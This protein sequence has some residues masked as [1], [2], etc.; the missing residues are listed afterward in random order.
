MSVRHE[1]RKSPNDN[2]PDEITLRKIGAYAVY[3]SDDERSGSIKGY[4]TSS[5]VAEK[6]AEKSGWY[7]SDG[8]VQSVT[9]HTDGKNLYEVKCLGQYTDVAE[10]EHKQMLENVLGK[11]TE[12]EVKFLIKN[13]ARLSDKK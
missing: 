10:S 12:D 6:R 5:A 1:S 11:L 4:Y 13:G 7:G 8:E 9:L 3:S 2:V